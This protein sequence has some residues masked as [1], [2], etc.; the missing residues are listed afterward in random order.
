MN[1]LNIWDKFFHRRRNYI[2]IEAANHLIHLHGR[3]EETIKVSADPICDAY[4]VVRGQEGILHVGI[5]GLDGTIKSIAT[6]DDNRPKTE[7]VCGNIKSMMELLLVA[8]SYRRY[9]KRILLTHPDKDLCDIMQQIID[10]AKGY[11]WLH[12]HRISVMR[13]VHACMEYH[14]ETR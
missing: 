2:C 11:S 14:I 3:H 12:G 7:H 1:L 13:G 9:N 6:I 5:V 4:L 10:Q 8:G